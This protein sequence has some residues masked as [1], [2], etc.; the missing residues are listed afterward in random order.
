MLQEYFN[1]TTETTFLKAL[2]SA[3]QLP[4]FKLVHEGSLI[5]QDYYYIYNGKVIQCT[6]TGYI[7]K[8]ATFKEVSHYYFCNMD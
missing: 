5:F 7:G 2:L 1:K 3:V 4:K 6:K 8:K